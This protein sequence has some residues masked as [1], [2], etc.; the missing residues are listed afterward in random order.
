MDLKKSLDEVRQRENMGKK[1]FVPWISERI[2]IT[3]NAQDAFSGVAFPRE[4][5]DADQQNAVGII[6]YSPTGQLLCP[7]DH[8]GR[9]WDLFNLTIR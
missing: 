1:H 6:I 4:Q 8:S 5:A 3:N 7:K 2:R 9:S